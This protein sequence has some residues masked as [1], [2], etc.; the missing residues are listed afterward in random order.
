M[1]SS[2]VKP[3]LGMTAAEL[4]DL[5][6]RSAAGPVPAGKVRGTAIFR[7]GTRLTAP[8]SKTTRL[9]WQGKVFDPDG[10]SAINRFFGVRIIR[11]NVYYAESWL[12]GAPSLILD[13]SRTSH[14][15]ARYRDEIRQ[16]GPDLYLGLMYDR[17]T[18]Q[19][20]L[21]MYFLL[22]TPPAH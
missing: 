16:V 21:K 7:P 12:D 18:P 4:D 20:A 5:Y 1:A 14:L 15:Y 11:A 8:M 6:R 3:L 2:G 22:E 17:T 19:P 10:S 9:M 13:Y